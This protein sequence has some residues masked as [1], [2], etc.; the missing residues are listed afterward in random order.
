MR[1]EIEEY[2][3][4]VQKQVCLVMADLPMQMTQVSHALLRSSFK[5]FNEIMMPTLIE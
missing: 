3:H 2:Q 4:N 1:Q 5:D